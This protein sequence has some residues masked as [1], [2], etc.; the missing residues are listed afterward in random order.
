MIGIGFAAGWTPCVGPILGTILLYASTTQSVA[1]GMGL[2]TFY[3]LGLGVPLFLTSLGVNSFLIY[4][5][6]VRNYLQ[7][8]TMVS[9]VFVIAVGCRSTPTVDTDYI[10]FYRNMV[11]VGM[12]G[13]KFLDL[14]RLV[15]LLLIGALV[16]L[17]KPSRAGAEAEDEDNGFYLCRAC[18]KKSRSW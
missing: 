7:M 4:F 9:G 1:K 3:S 15:A 16:E 14:Q 6:Q 5:K 13:N 10:F 12:W 8:I 2:L 11:S 17:V 18:K